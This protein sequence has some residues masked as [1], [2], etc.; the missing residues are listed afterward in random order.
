MAMP[1]EK[2]YDLFAEYAKFGAQ[3]K[4]PL[5]SPEAISEF[6]T[7]VEDA[8]DDALNDP[9]FVHGQRAEAMFE[10]MVISLGECLLIKPEKCLTQNEK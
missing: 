4:L 7:H 8:V 10:S 6:V 1:Q 3:K 2:P 9:A 5:Y